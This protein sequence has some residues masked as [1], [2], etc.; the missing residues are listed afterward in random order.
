[1]YDL[2]GLGARIRQLRMEKGFTQEAFA[3]E[4]GVT[5]QAVSKWETGIGCPDIGMLP[6]LA[7]ILGV[8]IDSLFGEA[9]GTPVPEFTAE[10]EDIKSEQSKPGMRVVHRFNGIDCTSDLEIASI[11]GATVIF[12]DGSRA[13]L[14]TRTIV[15]YGKGAII[16]TDSPRE[17]FNDDIFSKVED[18]TKYIGDHVN[19]AIE[20]G[21]NW[22]RDFTFDNRS[23]EAPK[24]WNG[25]NIKSLDIDVH[26]G[27]VV[28][29]IGGTDGQWSVTAEGRREFLENL[30]CAEDGDVLKILCPQYRTN[31]RSF[32]FGMFGDR[33]NTI[34]IYTGFESGEYFDVNLRGSGEI[35][36]GVDFESSNVSVG[37]S[38]DISLKN[39]GNTT[40]SVS[41]SGDIECDSTR[42]A[43]IRVSGS[44]DIDIKEV[45]GTCN[46]DIRGSGDADIGKIIGKAI[47]GISGS[48]DID[49]G[50]IDLS[51]FEVQVSGAGDVSVKSGKTDRLDLR[52][53]GAGSF[54]GK[55]IEAGE[56]DVHLN[57]PSD[58]VIGRV[59]GRST[60]HVN[61][62]SKLVIL[63]RG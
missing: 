43:S 4:L 2:S 11:D 28:N 16:I 45:N 23:S 38:G 56:L 26:G 3:N 17:Y 30:T 61:R 18:V 49:I 12:T 25:E 34:T 53:H 29:I 31:G 55:N 41:G 37:G 52:L 14:A 60:E 62:I 20:K 27:V 8:S 22:E 24:T 7:R 57:G 51:D 54:D 21:L 9:D 40:C 19:R 5:A 46:I 1:M 42:N 10:K 15:N 59:I 36:C 33:K 44:G 6:I 13:D 48:G 63:R 35:N 47:C 58:V 39:A 32:N 50:Y